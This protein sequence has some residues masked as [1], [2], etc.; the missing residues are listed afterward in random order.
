MLVNYTL[1]QFVSKFSSKYT[2]AIAW[3]TI[4]LAER[5]FNPILHWREVSTR[6]SM[7]D[8][9][10]QHPNRLIL[11]GDYILMPA[12]SAVNGHGD[13][14]VRNNPDNIKIISKTGKSKVV[15]L[16]EP[17]EGRVITQ[18]IRGLAVDKN[19]NVYVVR[20]LKTSTEIGEVESIVLDVLDEN[21]NVKQDS[22]RLEYLDAIDCVM[23]AVTK[24]ND[25]VVI[26]HDDPQVFVIDNT[27]K[28]KHVFERGSRNLRGLGICGQ[29]EIMVSSGSF[30][31]VEIYSQEGNLKSTIKLP[32]GH[33]VH[34][35]AFNYVICK[36]I[37]LTR[38]RKKDSYFLLCYTEAGELE[39]ETFFCK[40][41][42]GFYSR[43]CSHPSGPIAIVRTK[44]ITFI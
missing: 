6:K 17:S 43:I 16:P 35:F 27:G 5:N 20:R 19:N 9:L 25:I 3:P 32:E 7:G 2:S 39:T 24:N 38:V 34:G 33:E 36:I 26:Q 13:V 10:T 42:D 31:I 8:E 21:Y 28:L 29:D 22:R 44:S 14:I 40:G 23:I 15:K 41:I 12:Y 30:Q 11:D 4:E 1:F 37:V 18:D